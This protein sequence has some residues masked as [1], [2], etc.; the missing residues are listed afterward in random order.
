M[1]RPGSFR[2][3]AVQ[4]FLLLQILVEAGPPFFTDDPDPVPLHHWEYYL[5]SQNE[6]DIRNHSATGTLP[7]VEVNWGAVRNV[8][9]HLIIPF[10]YVF[11]TPSDFIYGYT[12][13]EVGVKYRFIKE[14][15]KRPEIGVFPIAEVPTIR[16]PR[17][18]QGN[19][20]VFLPVWIQK[21]WKQL[22]TYGG[23]GYWIN[24]GS[25]NQNWIFTGW[26]VQYGFTDF[27]TLG[28]EAYFETAPVKGE[29]NV[30][31]VTVGGFL[32]F[33]EYFHFIFSL[34]HTLTG[35]NQV[36]FYAG[37]YVTI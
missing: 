28:T 19:F 23:A 24:P 15:E 13:T 25:G 32:N 20:Q 3:T 21:S 9:I 6:F 1:F 8:Q 16:D 2:L 7:H 5:S 29:N 14:T 34:G 17:F 27:F 22:T 31:G 36:T 33:S 26:E 10:T 37:L 35:E 12:N 18:S 30:S 4:L 11:N